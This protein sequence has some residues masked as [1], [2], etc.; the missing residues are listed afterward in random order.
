MICGVWEADM[1]SLSL[2]F[3]CLIGLGHLGVINHSGFA[4]QDASTLHA[5]TLRT[6]TPQKIV[7]DHFTQDVPVSGTL[8]K[9]ALLGPT[10]HKV[11]LSQLRVYIPDS[12]SKTMCVQLA[13]RDGRYTG[14]F[15]YDIGGSTPGQYS[16]LISSQWKSQIDLY[17]TDELA[18]LVMFKEDCTPLRPR[19]SIGVASWGT[20]T[21]NRHVT[22]LLN[23]SRLDAR[24]FV[25]G[26]GGGKIYD[27]REL[28]PP[29]FTAFDT[30][31]QVGFG[32][33]DKVKQLNIRLYRFE[34]QLP[35]VSV[36]IILP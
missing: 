30:E 24:V 2:L 33:D 25:P 11:D 27:C 6:L 13:S 16:L 32:S 28:Q 20:S 26:A 9:G 19:E 35:E 14:R 5:S 10:G 8:L 34:S 4:I 1:R 7:E 12:H 21:D 36:Q 29:P 17:K 15:Q 18:V 23:A 3:S 31:C 22:L